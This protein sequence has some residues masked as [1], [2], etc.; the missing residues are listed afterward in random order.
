MEGAVKERVHRP[1]L[2]LGERCDHVRRVCAVAVTDRHDGERHVQVVL[3]A[4]R[5]VRGLA[6][7]V[8]DRLKEQ[9]RRWR[10]GTRGD[11]GRCHRLAVR[12]AERVLATVD[13][14]IAAR[15][16]ANDPVTLREVARDALRL[17]EREGAQRSALY[18]DGGGDERDDKREAVLQVIDLIRQYICWP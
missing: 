13:R 2:R 1:V 12:E 18:G 8:P 11:E 10:D 17:L 15:R 16:I 6:Q 7:R 3:V 9:G 5:R 4:V 14:A